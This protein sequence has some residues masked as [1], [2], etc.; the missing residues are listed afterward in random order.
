MGFRF[1]KRV[2]LFKGA[3]INP[4]W[5]RIDVSKGARI[6]TPGVFQIVIRSISSSE[7]SSLRRS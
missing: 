2:R 3:W 7:I 1:R 6:L 5:P 4:G